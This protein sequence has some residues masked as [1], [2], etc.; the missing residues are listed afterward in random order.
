LGG[1]LSPPFDILAPRA[2]T[3]QRRKTRLD[4]SA[5]LSYDREMSL[6]TKHTW[7]EDIQGIGL[8][9]FM[10]A[11]G[12][13]VLT[14]VGLITGQTAGIAVIL[15]YLTGF[16]FGPIFFLINIPF[17][18]VAW[19]R[20]GPAFTVKSLISVTL[21][22]LATMVLPQWFSIGHLTTPLGAVM[23]GCLTGIGLLAM[24]RH[25]G[26]LGG[27]GVVALLLQDKL[28]YRAGYVQLCAD[29]VIFTVALFLFPFT[30]VAWSVLGALVL[31]MI[32]AIN[33]RRDRYIAT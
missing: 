10:C 4:R 28:G 29:A 26:S 27:L 18:A 11:L 22:S 13:Q 14:H 23:A 8:G 33:H 17:Y 25:N 1:D 12:V 16:P 20:M 19:F 21:L 5:M 3:N 31:N 15:S 7:N 30:T 32:I 2:K 9:I 6:P 24:F